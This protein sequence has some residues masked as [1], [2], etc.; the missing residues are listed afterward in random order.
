MSRP[1]HQAA[2]V[3]ESQMKIRQFQGKLRL[4]RISTHTHTN[5]HTYTHTL[6]LLYWAGAPTRGLPACNPSNSKLK[7]KMT[8]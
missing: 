2:L 1:A 4:L 7:E 5:T 3:V 8:S 6:S